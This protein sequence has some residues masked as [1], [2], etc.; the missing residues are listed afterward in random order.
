MFN[1]KK[2]GTRLYTLI[3]FLSVLLVLIGFVGLRS[4]KLSD[5]G[6]DT[7][8]MDRV[9]PLK[10]LKVIA[11]MYAVN[12][13]DTSHKVR[14]GN[15]KWDEGRKNVA[16]ALEVIAKK[17]KEYLAT[18][19]VPEEKKLIE[20][21][22]PLMKTADVEMAKLT[23]IL[24]REDSEALT[25]FTVSEL[26]PAI[27]PISGKFSELVDV[28][29]KVAK[30][31]Y[32]KCSSTYEQSKR[33]NIALILLGVLLGNG[34]GIM[35]A[36]SITGPVVKA[37]NHVETMAGGDFSTQLHIS[38][39][40]EIGLMAASL[41]S[42]AGQL[43]TMIRQVI[44]GVKS[45]STSSTGLAAVSQQLSVSA[46]DTAGKSGSVAAATEQM[47]ANIQSVSTAMEQSS[48]NVSMVASAT[49]EMTATV[50]EIGQSAEKARAVSERAVMQSQ[51]TSG[52][53]AELGESAK[54]IGKVT[55]T[56][57]EISEQTN[58][59]A[60]NATIEASR[61]GEAGKGFAVVANEIKELARQTA[62]ATVDIRNQIEEM[63]STTA[64]TVDGI[65]V[66][67]GIINEVNAA[68]NGIASAVTEQVAATGE[69]STNISQAALGINEVNEHMA[70]S[71]VVV[72][73]ITRD[74]ALINQ[75]SNQV[76][77]G[78]N[79]VQASAKDLTVLSEQLET[80]VNQFKVCPA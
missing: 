29:L 20:E 53:M 32:D 73:D 67:S 33:I 26:Y 18:T 76:G 64:S 48:I 37:A 51:L 80:L 59:L 54:K 44:D 15:L 31:E 30:E 22:M 71:A 23:D 45:L 47:S 17:W 57:T 14:N 5:D 65:K 42:M 41:N 16:E 25:A 39:K 63:Q 12:I 52:K 70:Q 55:A 72:A 66:I 10:E 27:D 24:K 38:Q 21:A 13:V 4:A 35:V 77:E 56:I 36:R 68:I 49:E 7:V 79:Q 19:L 6:L 3:G 40:D 9:V 43:S 74:I 58:L 62:T 2:V 8:Y 69:I 75:Q 50:N 46:L 34:F 1:T 11:D 28:Q 61:A 60:L 78:S